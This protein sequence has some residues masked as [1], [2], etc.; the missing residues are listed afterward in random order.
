M[1]A[2]DKKIVIFGSGGHARSILTEVLKDNEFKVL[3]FI[4]EDKPIG[5]PVDSYNNVTYEVISSLPM[6]SNVIDE[7][8][9]GIIGVGLNFLRQKIVNEVTNKYPNFKWARIIS[10]DS[11]INGNVEIDDGTIILSASIIN[12]GTC[13]GK[14]CIINTRTILEHD[15]KFADFTSTGPDVTTGGNVIVDYCS[16]IGLGSSINNNVKISENTVIGSKSLCTKNCEANSIYIG[17]PAQKQK[18][19]EYDEDYL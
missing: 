6:L 7:Y 3:G 10:K 4:D 19:R 12:T 9:Y 2:K 11:I 8:T 1:L 5:T 15:N 16:H 14:H 18:N 13:I 17:S